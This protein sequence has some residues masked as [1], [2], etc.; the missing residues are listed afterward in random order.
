MV[1]QIALV[2]GDQHA[3]LHGGDGFNAVC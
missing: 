3:R 1:Q 2:T